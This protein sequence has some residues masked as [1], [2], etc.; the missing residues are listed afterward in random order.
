MGRIRIRWQWLVAAIDLEPIM[1]GL[2]VDEALLSGIIG[3]VDAD[4]ATC[5][6]THTFPF[7]RRTAASARDPRR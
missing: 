3:G 5:F 2:S 4:L 7:T 6:A 1:D